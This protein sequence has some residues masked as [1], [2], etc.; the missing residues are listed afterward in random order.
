MFEFRNQNTSGLRRFVSHGIFWMALDVLNMFASQFSI[1][2]ERSAE[3]QGWFFLCWIIFIAIMLI[4]A[5]GLN[6]SLI[7]TFVL[8]LATF[9][10][11][12]IGDLQGGPEGPVALYVKVGGYVGLATAAAAWYVAAA[13]VTNDTFGYTVSSL[14]RVGKRTAN[15]QSV[16]VEKGKEKR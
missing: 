16:T 11:L 8:L 4:A 5:F 1:A 3:A 13:D 10:L 12:T 7:V 14:E 2:P 6:V 15:L 9:V